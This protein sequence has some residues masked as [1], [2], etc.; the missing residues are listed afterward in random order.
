MAIE[1]CQGSEVLE[2]VFQE[3]G[4]KMKRMSRIECICCGA[5]Q[6]S[7][8]CYSCRQKV[9]ELLFEGKDSDLIVRIMMKPRHVQTFLDS[10]FDAG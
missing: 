2:H 7:M 5:I 1:G 9:N 4:L 3:R 8:V 10:Y 6:G